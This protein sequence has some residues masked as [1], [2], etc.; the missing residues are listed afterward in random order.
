MELVFLTPVT[1]QGVSIRMGAWVQNGMQSEKVACVNGS[2][3]D[4]FLQ[5][6]PASKLDTR[7]WHLLH[8]Y[9]CMKHDLPSCILTSN[10]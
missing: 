1:F 9:I 2:E 5:Y 4:A 8:V 6:H 7:N 3:N 10:E